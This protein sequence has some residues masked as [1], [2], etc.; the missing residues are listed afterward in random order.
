MRFDSLLSI[1]LSDADLER[2]FRERVV[3]IFRSDHEQLLG[4]FT[5]TDEA[6]EKKYGI[7]IS[8][9]GDL[10]YKQKKKKA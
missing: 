8:A 6:F 7:P 10:R 5:L 3:E 9:M 1:V 4:V 2:K